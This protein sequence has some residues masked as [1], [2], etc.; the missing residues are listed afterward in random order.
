VRVHKLA[1]VVYRLGLGK[2]VEITETLEAT[3]GNA[4]VVRALSEK[5]VYSEL[6]LENGRMSK[7]FRGD[8][9]VGALGRRRALRGYVGDV[10]DGVRVGDIVSL[11]N[12]GGVIG[13]GAVSH[14]DLGAPV[15]CEVLGMPVRDG[16]IVN[17]ADA[18][19]PAIDSL[20]G[21]DIPAVLIV[22]GTSMHSGKT[23]LISDLV[24]ELSKGG[25]QI[26][27]GKLTGV[28]CLRDLISMED[29][30]ASATASFLDVGYPSTAGLSGL[31]LVA[32]ARSVL[33]HLASGSP[34]LIALELGDGILGEYGVFDVLKD[35][36]IAAVTRMHI[37]CAA[38]PVGAWGGQKFLAEHGLDVDLFSGPCTDNDVGVS[39]IEREL[40]K[41][42]INAISTPE[43]LASRV[44]EHMSLDG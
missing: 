18:S 12:L 42:A 1:S 8:I 31:E 21:L 44:R 20:A 2:D 28:A 33:A 26:A 19:L 5:R 17:V 11:L 24:Q 30:G 36:E 34:D 9:L 40:G 39:F 15:S 37:F 10:P 32:L 13:S 14:N 29:H 43:A 4:I 16:R 25:C 41:P 6:E 35:P 3:P 7:I 22:S 38:D 27:G 23:R